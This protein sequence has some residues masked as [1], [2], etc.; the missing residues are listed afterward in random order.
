[1]N[2]NELWSVCCGATITDS[3]LCRDC[4]EHSWMLVSE[5]VSAVVLNYGDAKEPVIKLIFTV[6]YDESDIDLD[7]AV[8]DYVANKY[9]SNINYIYDE[10]KEIEISDLDF[11]DT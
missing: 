5:D 6:E 9:G 10:Y 3:G 7:T 1:M 4:K 2:R 11:R 8:K